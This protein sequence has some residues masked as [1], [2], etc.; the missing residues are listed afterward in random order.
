MMGPL[1]AL[2]YLDYFDTLL[3][4]EDAGDRKRART[5]MLKIVSEVR[6]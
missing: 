6:G 5:H 3:L 2:E 1:T 4:S